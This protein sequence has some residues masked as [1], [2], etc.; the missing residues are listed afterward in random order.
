MS[1]PDS[2]PGWD[3]IPF[4]VWRLLAAFVA[5]LV[6]CFLDFLAFHPRETFLS[7]PPC[8]QL[9]RWMNKKVVTMFSVRDKRPLGLPFHNF[10]ERQPRAP[11]VP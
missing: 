2:A 1:S 5:M 6:R 7:S 10:A 8:L 11:A 4:A 3:A 9:I